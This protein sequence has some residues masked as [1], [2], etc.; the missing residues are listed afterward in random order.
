MTD[1][2]KRIDAIMQDCLNG[3]PEGA[4]IIEGVVRKFG[5]SNAKIAEHREEIRALLDEMP[6]QFHKNKGGG[7]S[8]LNLAIDKNGQQWG[9]QVNAEA[10]YVLGAAVGMAKFQLPRDMWSILP[11]GVPYIVFDTEK[12]T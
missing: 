7:W 6:A 3:T 4:L 8:F 5:L 12:T 11:G 9:E 10:L 1:I 2:A